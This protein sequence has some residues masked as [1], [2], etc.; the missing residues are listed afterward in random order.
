M[1]EATKTANSAVRIL[2]T[3][4]ILAVSGGK[5]VKL[6]PVGGKKG[7]GGGGGLLG[8]IVHDIVHAGRRAARELPFQIF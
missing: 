4:E 1:R 3:D 5:V 2:S 7:H 6:Q 8:E